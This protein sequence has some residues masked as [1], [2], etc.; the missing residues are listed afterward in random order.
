MS[1]T[2]TCATGGETPEWRSTHARSVG[3]SLSRKNRLRIVK[4]ANV[5]SDASDATPALTPLSSSFPAEFTEDDASLCAFWAELESTP[6]LL[7]PSASLPVALLRRD[8]I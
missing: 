8:A 2:I 4:A 5:A 1:P 7:R 3:P 6:R